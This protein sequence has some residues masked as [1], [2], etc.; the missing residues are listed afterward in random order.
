LAL[1]KAPSR[2]PV[3]RQDE[4]QARLLER[5][6]ARI[7]LLLADAK[8]LAAIQ[9]SRHHELF[10]CSSIGHYGEQILSISAQEAWEGAALGTAMKAFPAL[11]GLVRNGSVTASAGAALAALVR[12]EGA[13]RP[14]DEWLR[15]ADEDSAKELR[16]RVAARIR[17]VRRARGEAEPTRA[18]TVHL[19]MQGV[20]DLG[21]ARALASRSEDELLSPSGAVETALR[22]Y[23]KA[24]DVLERKPGPRRQPRTDLPGAL[25]NRTVAAQNQRVVLT[26][27]RRKCRI[28]RCDCDVFVDTVHVFDRHA[29]GGSRE[30]E[31]LDLHCKCHHRMQ[32]RGQIRN[33]GTTDS[34]RFVNDRGESLHVRWLL[35]SR[36]PPPPPPADGARVPTPPG[37]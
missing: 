21:R 10:D 5:R 4:A 23:V 7:D 17:D 31:N 27:A 13:L 20:E 29:D 12:C 26:R 8:D 36:G 19:T 34:P 9:A 16:R 6:A 25:H 14:D 2:P 1:P 37:G 30:P 3:V 15:W 11:E 33:D 24:K 35:R 28:P 18:I 22:A 32:E